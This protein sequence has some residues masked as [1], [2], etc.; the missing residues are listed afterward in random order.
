MANDLGVVQLWLDAVNRRD[1]AALEA[2]T[3]PEVEIAGPRGSG[4]MPRAVLSEWLLRAGF[5]AEPRRWFCGGDGAVVVELAAVWHDVG[6]GAD[7]ER[8]LVGSRFQVR[9]GLVTSF[10]RHDSGATEAV[11]AAGLDEQ[12]DLV[13]SPHREQSAVP[14]LGGPAQ[15]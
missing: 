13:T 11:S 12:R 5:S 7:Q 2:L 9:D 6:S 1:G 14:R 15:R 3:Q 10:A 4:P 8:R